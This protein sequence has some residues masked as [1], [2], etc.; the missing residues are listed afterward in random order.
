VTKLVIFGA[1]LAGLI[2][3]RML[4][5]REPVIHERQASLPNNH[6]AILRF[7][8]GLVGD[9]TN[10]PFKKVNVL[11]HVVSF[12]ESNPIRD[13]ILYSLKVSGKAHLR[14]ILDVRPA[15]RYVAPPD[16]IRR[17]AVT[18]DIQYESDFLSWSADLIREGRADVIST[19]PVPEMMGLFRWEDRPK[20]NSRP[21]WTVKARV[22]SELDCDIHATLY[23]VRPDQP[24]YRASITGDMLMIEGTGEGLKATDQADTILNQVAREFGFK[25]DDFDAVTYHANKY[26]KI[27]DLD[28]EGRES[29]KRFMMWL[30]SEY[31]IYSLGRFATWRPKLLL[32]DL[33]NDVRVISRLMGGE[34]NYNKV[35]GKD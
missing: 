23:S 20:F 17:L 11:K 8:S 7:R 27:S 2:A 35:I 15:E 13:A 1:G 5:D 19:I 9:V 22:R 25:Y 4:A 16:M 3:A 34:S 6:H 14:S 33:V 30:S 12:P 10:V 31:R 24:W 26:Q 28:T 21:G 32:D 18:A 29:V